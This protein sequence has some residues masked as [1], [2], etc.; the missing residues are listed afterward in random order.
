MNINAIKHPM[1]PLDKEA[2]MSGLGANA[3][4]S[5]PLDTT[6]YPK[7]KGSSSGKNGIKLRFDEPFYKPGPITMKAQGKY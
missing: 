2:K 4:W 7:G 5:G 6:A 3:L 1:V